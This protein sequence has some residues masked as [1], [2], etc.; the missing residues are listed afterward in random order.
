M[1]VHVRPS[2]L[3]T[4]ARTGLPDKLPIF[5]CRWIVAVGQGSA[6]RPAKASK[7]NSIKPIQIG[8]I[9]QNRRRRTQYSNLSCFQQLNREKEPIFG[10]MYVYRSGEGGE[11][12]EPNRV[13]PSGISRMF[14]NRPRRTQRTYLAYFQQLNRE[15]WPIF[16]EMYVSRASS[17]CRFKAIATSRLPIVGAAGRR[18]GQK[19]SR[20]NS[21]GPIHRQSGN[22]RHLVCTP[23][24]S[25][26]REKTSTPAKPECRME[27]TR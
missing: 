13:K 14:R 12:A 17:Y 18:R 3:L 20:T 25:R 23:I 7:P 9:S 24:R 16:R 8:R 4:P 1:I 6:V 5:D 19:R 2:N 22:G 26:T 11:P 27:S 10:E 15:R 21:R